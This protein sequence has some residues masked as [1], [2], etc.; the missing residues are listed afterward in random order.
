MSI[1]SAPFGLDK[2]AQK[3]AFRPMRVGANDHIIKGA[4]QYALVA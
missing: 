2:I 1:L 3:S 4:L